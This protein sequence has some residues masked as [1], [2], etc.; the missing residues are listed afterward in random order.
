M[1]LTFAGPDRFTKYPSSNCPFNDFIFYPING[2][3]DEDCLNMDDCVA[4]V[5]VY[6]WAL[7]YLKR[8]RDPNNMV[9]GDLIDNEH[10]A[11][12]RFN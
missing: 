8:V 12:V 1:F 11:G 4:Y 10:L 9:P 6:G 2:H 3:C 5:L 7:C